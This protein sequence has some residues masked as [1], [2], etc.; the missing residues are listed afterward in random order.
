MFERLKQSMNIEKAFLLLEKEDFDLKR[1]FDQFTWTDK[2]FIRE[3]MRQMQDQGFEV[4]DLAVMLITPYLR[5]FPRKRRDVLG[6]IIANWW[7]EK[8]IQPDVQDFFR[9]EL[10]KIG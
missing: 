6:G 3:Q 8:K 1:V 7:L 2:A 10:A 5:H 9:A 4:H